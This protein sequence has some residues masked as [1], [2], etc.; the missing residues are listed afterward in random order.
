M[1]ME[2]VF[3]VAAVVIFSV[4]EAATANLVSLWFIGG[5]LA[6][7]IASFLHAPVWAQAVIFV[8]VSGALIALLRPLAKKHMAAKNEKLNTDRLI[9]QEGLVTEP[10]DAK[11]QT[12]AVR[13]SGVLWSARSE[14]GSVL[15]PQTLVRI[16][17]V[18]GSKVYVTP[19]TEK[20]EVES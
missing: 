9:G 10:I 12:G 19:V 17:R 6:A 8:A 2:N 7:M 5:A 15:E 20:Q 11:K 3:W 13:L 18:E 1:T 4:A 14:N 16:T